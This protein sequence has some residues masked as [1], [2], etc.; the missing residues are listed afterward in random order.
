MHAL[1]DSRVAIDPVDKRIS[2]FTDTPA[3]EF[4]VQ[5]RDLATGKMLGQLDTV[6][7][8]TGVAFA[9]DGSIVATCS[10]EGRISMWE[11]EP[12][13]NLGSFRIPA[14]SLTDIAFAGA[15]V[16]VTTK[17]REAYI[18]KAGSEYHVLGGHHGDLTALAAS[19]LGSLIATGDRTGGVR[20]WSST[21]EVL[22]DTVEPRGEV[23]S[24]LFSPDHTLLLGAGQ[25]PRTFVWNTSLGVR[26][27]VQAPDDEYETSRAF[28]WAPESD[29]FATVDA[30]GERVHIWRRPKANVIKHVKSAAS[31]MA[32]HV[33]VI[34]EGTT[35]VVD[36]LE[37]GKTR[38]KI[39]DLVVPSAWYEDSIDRDHLQL[40]R[41]GSRALIWGDGF[42]T[43]YV[44]VH[45]TKLRELKPSAALL[46]GW[47]LGADGARV[48]E[49]GNKHV[50]VI[51]VASGRV[52]LDKDE[53]TGPGGD[54]APDGDHL[55]IGG[56]TLDMWR[57]GTGDAIAQRS[58]DL[59]STTHGSDGRVVT[60][61]MVPVD[62]RFDP[63]GHRV[64]ALGI[65]TPVIASAGTGATVSRLRELHNNVSQASF[66]GSGRRV[67][68][69]GVDATTIVWDADTGAL[70]C[71]VPATSPHAFALSSD[72]ERLATGHPDGTIRI[73][74]LQG[75]L[76]E[77]MHNHR[78][79]IERLAFSDDDTRLL[80]QSADGW[81]IEWDVHVER[82][83]PQEIA[84]IAEH[85]TAWQVSGGTLVRRKSP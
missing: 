74:D 25:D 71:S 63:T 8:V 53:Q 43:V 35:L 79:G 40:S 83:T 11:L 31:A 19:P 7:H 26:A 47:I 24:L 72:G 9:I 6:E 10:T 46:G 5:I 22:G 4:G 16:V 69:Q 59:E 77:T 27:I 38:I 50:R 2:I 21:G 56:D 3:K 54:L 81:A 14:R 15:Q 28:A 45:G 64:I 1:V 73:W 62:A 82:R 44:L 49:L 36:D 48:V 23:D 58:L 12:L 30:S 20:L 57:I 33:L 18:W 66:D 55:V 67:A 34:V 29:A 68:T 52:V 75:R 51:D 80:S 42:A 78:R 85:A 17:E 65:S 61:T 39:P 32:G 84:A 41:D 13:S 60:T 37:T 76:L 70:L